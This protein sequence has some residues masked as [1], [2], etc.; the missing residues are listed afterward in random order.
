M[1]YLKNWTDNLFQMFFMGTSWVAVS[2]NNI[3]TRASREMTSR[4]S[5]LMGWTLPSKACGGARYLPS[6]IALLVSAIQIIF[7]AANFILIV[8]SGIKYNT[9]F[10]Y[11]CIYI[12]G[13]SVLP[14]LFETW[15][16]N[17]DI[18]TVS[19]IKFKSN[20]VIFFHNIYI[21]AKMITTF[22]CNIHLFFT[23]CLLVKNYH[24]ST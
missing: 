21:L 15:E 9:I 6:L 24:I 4:F 13:L 10:R 3:K 1:A 23:T 2:I 17:S 18:Y 20:N 19:Q 22:I 16:R 14:S 8:T 12:K 7:R 11:T 5:I